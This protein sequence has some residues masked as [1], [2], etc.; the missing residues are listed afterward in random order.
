MGP[1]NGD[2]R[3]LR[4]PEM[5]ASHPRVSR[6]TCRSGHCTGMCSRVDVAPKVREST[7]DTAMAIL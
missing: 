5:H 6:L 1:V 3:R 2:Q 7:L 4:P